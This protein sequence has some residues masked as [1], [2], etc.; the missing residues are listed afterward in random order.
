MKMQT[1]FRIKKIILPVLACMLAAAC[2][3]QDFLDKKPSSDLIVP[4]SLN[5]FQALMDNDNVMG[6]VPAL[7]E[8]STDN[9]YIDYFFW[10]SLGARIQNAY[11]WAGDIFQGQG[12]VEDWNVPYQQVYYCNVV[13]D[14]LA[15][16]KATGDNLVQWNT[17]KGTALFNRAFAFYNVA[18]VFALGYDNAK[19]S[20]D[21]GI[22]VRLT[23]S[24]ES[25]SVRAT[26]KQTYDQIVE[27]SARLWGYYPPMWPP[28]L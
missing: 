26:V 16:V 2:H 17:L 12:A 1:F 11:I 22:P 28:A 3:K 21:L 5:D 23:S 7:G 18:Q 25:A 24:I 20:T 4:S 15:E 13:L 9:Y 8:I 10:S 14:G 19:A 6:L 27:I